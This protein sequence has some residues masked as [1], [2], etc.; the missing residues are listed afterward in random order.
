MVERHLG[1]E[2]RS[3]EFEGG[4]MQR[5]E[6][7]LIDSN[8][9][10]WKSMIALRGLSWEEQDTGVLFGFLK[11]IQKLAKLFDYPRFIFTWDSTK[12]PSYRQEYYPDYKKKKGDLDPEMINLLETGKPQFRELRTHILPQIG[13]K[14]HIVQPKLEADDMIAELIFQL[15]HFLEKEGGAV[16]QKTTIISSDND[17]YQLIISNNIQMY[18]IK[19]KTSTTRSTFYSQRGIWPEQWAT[20]KALSGCSSDGVPGIPG[21]GDKTAIKYLR[22]ELSNGKKKQAIINNRKIIDFN[23][24]LVKLPHE[25]TKS[26][27]LLPDRLSTEEFVNIC[28]DFGMRSLI[29][30]EE[31]FKIWRKILE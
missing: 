27:D 28:L 30:K 10:C 31:N 19:N 6:I 15:H 1:V 17:L 22:R 2:S 25:R 5:K 13:L 8:Y 29:D 4:R 23:I 3:S 7:L 20:V 14:N 26:I 9:I 24:P 12:R 11:V 18:D 21:I 16:D